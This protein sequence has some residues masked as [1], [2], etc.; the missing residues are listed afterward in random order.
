MSRSGSDL[1]RAAEPCSHSC[2]RAEMGKIFRRVRRAI[3]R[4]AATWIRGAG[5]RVVV[6]ASDRGDVFV[7]WRGGCRLDL[8]FVATA[9]PGAIGS[10]PHLG[11]ETISWRGRES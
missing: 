7:G 9:P 1:L 2:A 8:G 4:G 5:S 6:S 11:E 3:F 10:A